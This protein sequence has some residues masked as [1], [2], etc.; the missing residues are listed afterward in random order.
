[1]SLVIADLVQN[2]KNLE[3]R[4][5]TIIRYKRISLDITNE[6]LTILEN[7][8]SV[9]RRGKK[10]KN[11]NIRIEKTRIRTLREI[12]KACNRIYYSS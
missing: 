8:K 2:K 12:E 1:M 3:K 6:T 10:K 9:R 4:I 11:N 5:P 7:I